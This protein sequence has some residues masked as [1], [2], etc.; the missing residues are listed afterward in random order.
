MLEATL[1]GQRHSRRHVRPRSSCRIARRCRI[2]P[3]RRAGE[4]RNALHPDR[5]DTPS[6]AAGRRWLVPHVSQP[7]VST[8]TRHRPT[9]ESLDNPGFVEALARPCLPRRP[10]RLGAPCESRPRG[11]SPP[12]DEQAEAAPRAGPAHPPGAAD[13]RQFQPRSSR[14]ESAGNRRGEFHQLPNRKFVRP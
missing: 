7:V 1:S 4:P 3:R 11:P 14:A 9:T 8:R 13:P 2:P 10:A 12:P 5:P 6:S